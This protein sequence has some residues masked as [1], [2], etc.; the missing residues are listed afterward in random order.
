MMIFVAILAALA[1]TLTV[2]GV[3]EFVPARDRNISRKLSELGL[4]RQ[5]QLYNLKNDLGEKHNVASEHPDLVRELAALMK[6]IR[7]DGRTRPFR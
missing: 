3:S 7:D 5:P 2:V 6:K 4:D 1:V